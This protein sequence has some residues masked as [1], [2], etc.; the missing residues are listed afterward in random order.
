MQTNQK[1]K[2]IDRTKLFTVSELKYR[3]WTDTDIKRFA[4]EHDDIRPNPKYQCAAPMKLYL[5][6]RVRRIELRKTWI[7]WKAGS[8][9]RKQSAAAAVSTKEQK[10]Q[11]YVDAIEIVVPEMG[12]DE[13]TSRAI[14]H[15]NAWWT[16]TEKRAHDSDS[17][18]FLDRISVNYLRHELTSYE[19]HLDEIA[20]KTGA[21]EARID[22]SGKVYD[23]I[24]DAYPDL[25]FECQE[26]LKRRM[27]EYRDQM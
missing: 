4:P 5:R 10:L 11:E 27:Q 2:H 3:G 12:T 1:E 15:Y 9:V 25:W 23:A 22:L 8:A 18:D 26:Q 19:E 24:G 21:K 14:Q 13:L 17:Q 6:A 16:G 7:A 20:G